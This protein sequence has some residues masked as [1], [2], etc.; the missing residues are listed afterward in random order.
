[1]AILLG[2]VLLLALLIAW[3]QTR[4]TFLVQ[5]LFFLRYPVLLA[6]AL[7]TGPVLAVTAGREMVGNLFFLD[8]RGIA[9]VMGLG[10]FAAS[11]VVYTFNLIFAL[12]HARTRLPFFRPPSGS[13]HGHA[14]LD[15]Q[16]AFA[17]RLAQFH[18]GVTA[19]VMLPLAVVLVTRCTEGAFWGG[20]GVVLGVAVAVVLSWLGSREVAQ[21]LKAAFAW[22]RRI[23]QGWLGPVDGRPRTRRAGSSR[24]PRLR[25]GVL[26]WL[27]TT[28]EDG[29]QS[30]GND[31]KRWHARALFFFALSLALYV[32]GYFA[33]GE[34]FASRD[35]LL[36]D[37]IPALAYLLVL[38]MVFGW[39]LPSLSFYFDKF[40]V[41]PVLMLILAWTFSYTFGAKD[42]YFTLSRLARA[43]PSSSAVAAP[44][45]PL[46]PA[47]AAEAWAAR[48]ARPGGRKPTMVVVAASGG[49]ITAS[50]WTAR[51]LTALASPREGLGPDFARAITLV[52]SASGGGLGAAY[53][54]DGYGADKPPA[55]DDDTRARIVEDAGASSLHD[56]AFA[57]A[58]SDLFRVL[59]P[60]LVRPDFPDRGAALENSWRRR[61]SRP[62][63]TLEHWREGV[64]AGWRPTQ[65]FNV[66]IAETGERLL[67]GPI[68]CPTH[69]CA[70]GGASWRG[71]SM[72][73]LYG[74]GRDIPVVTA[75]RLSATFPWVTPLSRAPDGNTGYHL[76]DGGYYDNFGVVTAI[77]WLTSVH[78]AH[79]LADLVD[80]VLLVQI[81][82]SEDRRQEPARGRGWF[83]ATLGPL[84]TL[85]NVSTTSQRNHNDAQLIGLK[86][87]LGQQEVPLE[88]VEFELDIKSP[89]SWHLTER[90]KTRIT[91]QWS[92]SPGIA[93]KR[94][95]LACLWKNPAARWFD[96]C[97]TDPPIDL[98]SQK[99]PAQLFKQ[100]ESAAAQAVSKPV[101]LD[102]PT[103]D[104]DEREDDDNDVNAARVARASVLQASA[105]R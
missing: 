105:P 18:F 13:G 12:G 19:A 70:Q 82:A 102:T 41:P 92:R 34:S 47:K 30:G 8:A 42:H 17:Q 37:A 98:Q 20:C 14:H 80:K 36:A 22:S 11:T 38:V 3:F 54:V 43:A 50:L 99:G 2:I 71:Q 40:R 64:S 77:E 56:T 5:Y 32:V 16:H 53:F 23:V 26:R 78:A 7:M 69:A 58:Y 96:E 100:V 65:I 45:C 104:D 89:L 51:V 83:Y 21:R 67:L 95:K 49:G 57:M 35:R 10:L 15:R 101:S 55:F 93:A 27:A 39:L 9:V 4:G 48:N 1:M 85:V 62:D 74:A 60:F 6:A 91:A 28:F 61:L 103:V 31:E 46:T 59:V 29:Y 94:E 86:A 88:T 75:A 72:L 90:E 84:V 44:D 63:L 68:D 24:R 79:N 81:R 52:S 73:D 76:A 33:V 97:H 25:S 66:T 87:L